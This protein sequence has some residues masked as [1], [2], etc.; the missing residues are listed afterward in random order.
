[1]AILE[2]SSPLFQGDKVYR[3]AGRKRID[4]TGVKPLRWRITDSRPHHSTTFHKTEEKQIG[5]AMILGI[6]MELLALGKN[7]ISDVESYHHSWQ[8][9]Q[10]EKEDVHWG[11]V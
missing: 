4:C 10:K 7:R 3:E 2:I 11:Y 9:T 6:R 8:V 5:A 1:M